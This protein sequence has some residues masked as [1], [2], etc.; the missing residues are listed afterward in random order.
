M[1]KGNVAGEMAMMQGERNS[2]MRMEKAQHGWREALKQR[3]WR[4]VEVEVSLDAEV[5][6]YWYGPGTC[7]KYRL[8]PYRECGYGFH[9]GPGPGRG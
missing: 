1:E 6:G 9:A 8:Y 4:K 2:M 5:E 7:V 3:R